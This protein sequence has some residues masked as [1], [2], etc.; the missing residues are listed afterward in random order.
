MEH[1]QFPELMPPAPQKR[2]RVILMKIIKVILFLIVFA[3]IVFGTIMAIKHFSGQYDSMDTIS[4]I[5]LILTGRQLWRLFY[6]IAI[7]AVSLITTL[8]LIKRSK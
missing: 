5:W 1:I 3:V 7:I 8:L 2:G 4:F 6:S